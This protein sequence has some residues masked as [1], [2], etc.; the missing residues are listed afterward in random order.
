MSKRLQSQIEKYSNEDKIKFSLG[1]LT[2]VGFCSFLIIIATFTQLSFFH[3]TFPMD[4]ILHPIRFFGEH[5]NTIFPLKYYEYIPQVPVII[6]ISTLLGLRYGFISVFIYII[7]GLTFFPIFALGGGP[8]YVLQYNFGYILAY[9]PAVVIVNLC[10]KNNFSYTSIAKSSCLGV[11][12]IHLI[13]IFYTI[14]ISF[15]KKDPVNAVLNWILI[16]SFAKIIYDF[17]FSFL[18]IIFAKLTRKILCLAMG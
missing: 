16:Q 2:L 11:I 12:T 4:A 5:H 7:L 17:I 8:S 1:T 13:G 10:L 15:I 18:A 3:Y 14:I 9:I 6:Y